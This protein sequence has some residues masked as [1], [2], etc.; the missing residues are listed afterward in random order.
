MLE[1]SSRLPRVAFVAGTLGQGGA[2]KQLVYMVR[3]L[4]NANFEVQLFSLRQGEHYERTLIELGVPPIHMG[5]FSHPL[6]RL[7]GITRAL[8]SFRPQ[9][10]HSAHFYT[11]AYA[12]IGARWAG[13]AAIGSLRNDGVQDVRSVGSLG[14]I[15][16]RLAPAMICNSQAAK[17]NAASYGVRPD[18]I[19]VLP[20]VIDLTEF[21]A[22][23]R[24]SSA[25]SIGPRPV[26]AAVA[27]LVPQ[28]RIDRFLK[29]LAIARR[30]VH[31][32]RGIVIGDGPA[33]SE[34][35][36]EA[37]QLGLSPDALSFLG[38][39][40]DVPALLKR[41]QMLV[42]TSDHEGFPNVI[43]EAMAAELPVIATPAGD[44]PAVI[45]EGRSGF[46]V[47]FEDV[48]G[49]AERMLRLAFSE[50][51]RRRM[52]RAGR[53][54]V[55]RDYPYA[56]LAERLSSIYAKVTRPQPRIRCPQRLRLITR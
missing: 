4:V 25:I 15:V 43:L 10:I 54:R 17:Q 49:M 34:L 51:E 38:Q 37:R 6:L 42:N 52:G 31:G 53:R 12:A 22:Q 3:A 8:R 28:K 47:P 32:L 30:H 9:V 1:P 35:E 55:E 23:S 40:D 16:I 19:H 41:V 56:T 21:D 27:R 29:A 7:T 26:A 45:E 48:G 2:E 44:T 18:S 11:N 50:S 14:K 5:R 39:R 13:G 20:N 36:A 33:R 46:L 24:Q